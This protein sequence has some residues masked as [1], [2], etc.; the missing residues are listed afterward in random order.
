MATN[1]AI[2]DTDSAKHVV[3]PRHGIRDDSTGC[4][5]Q[6]KQGI[7]DNYPDVAVD[8]TSVGRFS[9]LQFMLRAARVRRVYQFMH[10]YLNYK[11]NNWNAEF[12]FMGRSYGT[13]I[14]RSSLVH[15]AVDGYGRCYDC[16][17]TT[18]CG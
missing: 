15:R 18:V 10:E 16:F 9:M 12:H 3:F 2:T 1:S 13:Y 5:S 4:V 8:A 7:R 6:L 14:G 11:A 17:T